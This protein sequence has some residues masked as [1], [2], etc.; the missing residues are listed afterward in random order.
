MATMTTDETQTDFDYKITEGFSQAYF[1][2]Y[3]FKTRPDS[4]HAPRR[5][6]DFSDLGN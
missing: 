6:M 3:I 2:D 1:S 4:V 5:F